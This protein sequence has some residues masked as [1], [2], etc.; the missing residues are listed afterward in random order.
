VTASPPPGTEG[1]REA[2]LVLGGAGFLGAHL[3]R[4]LLERGH[5]VTVFDR[6][7]VSNR[8]LDTLPDAARVEGDFLNEADLRPLIE[9]HPLV[10][11]FVGNT[12][13]ASSNENPAYDVETN[14]VGTLRLLDLALECGVRRIVFPSSGGTVYGPCPTVPRVE[15]DPTHP[16]NAYGIGKLMVEKYLELYARLHGLDYQCFRFANPYGGDQTSIGVLGAVATFVERARRG[17]PVDVWGDGSVTRDY[18]HV[19]DAIDAVLRGLDYRGPCRV[20]NVGTGVGTSLEQ[21]IALIQRVCGVEIAVRRHA[22]RAADVPWNVLDASR[23]RTE[24]GWEAATQ[25][26]DG[27]AR[28]WKENAR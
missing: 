14:V 27:I 9:S 18:L 15:D 6:P 23:A 4:R 20:F 13:P 24:L 16:V 17:E 11:H 8:R 28:L 1:N 26:E 21:L 22:A 2:A 25:L 10:F 12:L 5:P 3:A 19:E 7:Q